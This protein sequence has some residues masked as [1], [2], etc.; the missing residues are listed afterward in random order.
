MLSFIRCVIHQRG[1]FDKGDVVEAVDAGDVGDV[2]DA[3]DVGAALGL[4]LSEGVDAVA[5]GEKRSV[6]GSTLLESQAR[7]LIKKYWLMCSNK[8][9][10]LT[11]VD[12][13]SENCKLIVSLSCSILWSL[14]FISHQ[15]DFSAVFF[16]ILIGI[17]HVKRLTNPVTKSQS[18]EAANKY[19]SRTWVFA[20][21]S[22]PARSIM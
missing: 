13:W 2:G 8:T 3:G 19:V 14:R 5:Q 21:R 11:R 17:C 12:L 9:H 15:A 10:S 1:N 20:A 16:H 18:S 7:V 22:L 4:L 6:D